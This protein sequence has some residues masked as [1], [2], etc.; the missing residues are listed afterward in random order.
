[1]I[2]ALMLVIGAA[3]AQDD[4]LARGAKVFA[5]SCAVGY[6]HGTAG[7]ANRGP[8]LAGRGF[9]RALVDKTVRDGVGGTA[10]PG[11][12][13][14][15]AADLNA[16][17]GYVVSISGGAASEVPAH[18]PVATPAAFEGP[19]EARRG[20][21]LFFDATRGTRCGTC[22]AM[23]DWGTPVGPN[24]AGTAARIRQVNASH[25]QTAVA[26]NDRFPALVVERKASTIVLYDLSIAPPVL[27]TFAAGK[28]TLQSGSPW[29]HATAIDSYSDADLEAI[30]AYLKWSGSRR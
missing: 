17:I 22:H 16:V 2:A 14:M 1:M 10:M 28:V 26:G 12:K 15:N 19:P 20:K 3:Y 6:C 8:R 30:A 29:K 24:L 25:V 4:A 7:S 27:R 13:T 5:Q 11:F 23:E 21:E 18:L 9:D